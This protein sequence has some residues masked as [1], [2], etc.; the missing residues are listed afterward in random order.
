MIPTMQDDVQQMIAK[1]LGIEDLSDAEQKMLI[2]QFGLVALKAAT[3]AVLEKLP[4]DKRA[5]YAKIA[6][7]GDATGLKAFLDTAVPS[8]DQIAQAA[9]QEEVKTFR[10]FQAK[11]VV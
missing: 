4:E 2:E 7:A 5:E 9:I 6:E 1:D 3:G 11:A 10:E 8:H